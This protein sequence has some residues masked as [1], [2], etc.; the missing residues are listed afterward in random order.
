MAVPGGSGMG[1]VGDPGDD[2]LHLGGGPCVGAAGQRTATYEC[3]GGFK[4]GNALC[5]A[6]A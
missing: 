2:L 1:G 4:V 5:G 3:K 6:L